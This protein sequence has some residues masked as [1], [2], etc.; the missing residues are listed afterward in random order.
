M[1]ELHVL[2]NKG[3]EAAACIGSQPASRMKRSSTGGGG[4]RKKKQKAP[5]VEADF[6][7]GKPAPSLEMKPQLT[8]V[9][10]LSGAK[11]AVNTCGILSPAPAP[12]SA[13][14]IHL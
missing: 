6:P 14:R 4:D 13:T 8:K 10:C 3:V 9:S 7:R 5:D 12:I 1:N 11:A 2:A